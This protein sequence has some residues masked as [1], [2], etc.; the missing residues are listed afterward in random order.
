M[1]TVSGDT[2]AFPDNGCEINFKSELLQKE[3]LNLIFIAHRRDFE[4]GTFDVKCSAGGKKIEQFG[5]K[6]MF[7]HI[8]SRI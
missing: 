5:V 6:G 2:K 4:F 1:K 8:W 3:G 7:E